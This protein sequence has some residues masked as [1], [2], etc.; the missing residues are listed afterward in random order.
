MKFHESSCRLLTLNCVR[1][2]EKWQRRRFIRGWNKVTFVPVC[3]NFNHFIKPWGFGSTFPFLKP[4]RVFIKQQQ[5]EMNYFT[6][7]CT[8]LL[9]WNCPKHG[10][11]TFLLLFLLTSFFCG[12]KRAATLRANDSKR[13]KGLNVLIQA[14]IPQR[15]AEIL[16]ARQPWDR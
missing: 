7:N 16:S 11:Q 15:L 8:K 5:K 10:I 12:Y 9:L 1:Y 14:A 6:E 2:G 3:M 13:F 4:V